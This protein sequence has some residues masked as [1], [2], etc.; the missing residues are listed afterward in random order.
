MMLKGD[1]YV[2]GNY[3]YLME[4]ERNQGKHEL[5]TA[6]KD[7]KIYWST[8]GFQLSFGKD[9]QF[10]RPYHPAPGILACS[11]RKAHARPAIFTTLFGQNGSEAKWNLQKIPRTAT[12]NTYLIYAVNSNRDALVMALLHDAHYQTQSNDLMEGFMETADNWFCDMRVKP[13][14]VAA[15]DSIWSVHIWKK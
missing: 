4:C 7:F 10:T 13:L 8:P 5:E 2:S 11:I 14:S 3:E 6:L 9:S 1:V 15:Q 12:S